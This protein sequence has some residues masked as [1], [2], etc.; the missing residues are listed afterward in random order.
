MK[1]RH[2]INP[3]PLP[4]IQRS[5]AGIGRLSIEV[6]K[7]LAALRDRKIIVSGAGGSRGGYVHPWKLQVVK[8]ESEIRLKTYYGAV[9]AMRLNNLQP[10]MISLES[11][12]DA[13]TPTYL[14]NDPYN[15]SGTI[16]HSVLSIST[17]YGVWVQIERFPTES[18]EGF[19]GDD[20]D[21]MSSEPLLGAVSIFVTDDFPD[22]DD[23]PDWNDDLAFVHVGTVAVDGDG[24][25]TI[26]QRLRS[27]IFL[28]IVAYP[29]GIN[30]PD[31]P[32]NPA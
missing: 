22:P 21:G 12:F 4:A 23:Q 3:I 2:G 20:Y 5:P 32:E 14:I 9:T 17:T 1:A 7:A 10:T 18:F 24:A 28:P 25:A 31:P 6:R 8:E 19:G 15:P 29:Y 30:F 11:R 13:A 27:D 26:K 16:G